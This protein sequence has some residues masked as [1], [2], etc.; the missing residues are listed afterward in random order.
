[1]N[2]GRIALAGAALWLLAFVG[3]EG[4]PPVATV[5]DEVRMLGSDMIIVN[6]RHHFTREG[7]RAATLRF[8]TAY[9]WNDSVNVHLA[10]PVLTVFNEDGSERATVTSDRGVMD[11]RAE[12]MIARQN[13]VL[14]V[15]G[16]ER[17]VE[18]EE[19]HYDPEGGRLWSDSSFTMVHEGRTLRGSAFTSDLEFRNFR[20]VGS[21]G[22]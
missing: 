12:G 14:I 1:M 6:G 9:Q 8:D 16:Q 11:R 15:P 3:C 5:S 22:G 18:T 20:V 2:P 7:I 21:E 10:G 17:R 13:V 4:E 19:L